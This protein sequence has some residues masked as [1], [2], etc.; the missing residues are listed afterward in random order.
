ME[1]EIRKLEKGAALPYDLLYLADPS[2]EAVADYTARGECWCAYAGNVPVGVYVLLPT[3][4][5][6][7]ELVNLAVDEC[8]QGRGIGKLLVMHA[9]DT[10]RGNGF[11]KIEVGTGSTGTVQ[12]ALYR[13]CGFRPEWIER[14]FFA[15][16]CSEPIME[17]G[18]ECRDM[19][20]LGIHLV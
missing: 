4:P 15:R 17:N 11:R 20:R 6:T 10:A 8:Y 7:A 13:K 2:R 9:V 12:L 19:V 5:C 1:P 3:R 16:H 14:G 18:V